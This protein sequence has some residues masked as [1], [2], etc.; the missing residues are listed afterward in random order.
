MPFFVKTRVL[1]YKRQLP[2]KAAQVKPL[3]DFTAEA[4]EV[5]TSCHAS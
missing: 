1:N 3:R 4:G 2:L 5:S